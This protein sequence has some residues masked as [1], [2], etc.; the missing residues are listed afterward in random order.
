MKLSEFDYRLPPER[1]A[2]APMEPRDA[3]RLLVL[4]RETG[5][6]EHRVFSDLKDYLRPGDVLVLN[7]TRVIPARLYAKKSETGGKAEILL[8]RHLVG[9]QWEAVIGG[10]RVLQ[11]TV[12]E[13]ENTDITATVIGEGDEALR[14]IE[15]SAPIDD[16][17]AESGD[18]P[19][20]P[21][22]TTPLADAERYQT[23]YARTEGSS[24]APTAGLHFTGDLLFDI[25]R[26]GVKI[27][28][29]TLHVGLDT[30]G[31]VRVDDIADHK[32]HREY[33]HLTAD[34]ARIINEA[35]LAGGRIIA[36]G[37]T[38]VRTL[39][40]AAIRSASFGTE[41]NDMSSVQ[42]TLDNINEKLCAWRP[43]NA[44]E[45]ETD[46]YITPGYRF[47]AVDVMITNFHLPKTTLLMMVSAFAGRDLILETYQE[48]IE[49][50]YRFYSFGDAMLIL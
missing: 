45:E 36:V 21:Y 12:L 10:R 48:A 24:A 16:Y 3:S 13:L 31:P 6:R 18:V 20:P 4:N 38:S 39:E 49:R 27:V 23:V 41:Y 30:F 26:M 33:A 40:T 19:L 37:T 50:E 5:E 17:L 43:V 44:I 14:V 7:Q 35:K 22:I 11:D 42:R 9:N 1:I 2:Q 25:Q 46:L 29:C 32:L 34:N 47:R 15:F 8:L 28:Y